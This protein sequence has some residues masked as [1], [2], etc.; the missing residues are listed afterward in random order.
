MLPNVNRLTKKKD[1]DLVFKQGETAKVD[2]LI[3]KTLKN[4]Y[5]ESR[6]GFIVSKKVSGKATVRNT[7]KRRLRQAVLNQLGRLKKSLDVVIVTLPGIEKKD[8]P[9]IEGVM[10]KVFKKVT[11]ILPD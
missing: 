9:T 5:P 10:E 2:F 4:Q 7:V 6:F 1:F 3:V 8:F 11:L